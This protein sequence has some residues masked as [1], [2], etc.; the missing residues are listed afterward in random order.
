M[1]IKEENRQRHEYT[2]ME[3]RLMGEDIKADHREQLTQL[4]EK[5]IDPLAKR[6]NS[7]EHWR[8]SIAGGFAVI[9][10][11]LKFGPHK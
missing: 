7:L 8:T 10:A 9:L 3:M 4:C 6:V 11:Y 1:S 5:K 2:L